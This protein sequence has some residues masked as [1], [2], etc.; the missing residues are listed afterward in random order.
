MLHPLR[1]DSFDINNVFPTALLLQV[2]AR[3]CTG[4]AYEPC[5]RTF[6][7]LFAA[8][9]VLR[10]RSEVV[11]SPQLCKST[12]EV[13]LSLQRPTSCWRAAASLRWW[14]CG[15][16][17]AHC[18]CTSHAGPDASLWLE[19]LAG[20]GAFAARQPRT[21]LHADPPGHV[22]RSCRY[23]HTLCCCALCPPLMHMLPP[24][25]SSSC[26]CA[27]WSSSISPSRSSQH[28]CM[29]CPHAEHADGRC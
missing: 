15:S 13:L 12:V 11:F 6:T 8:R 23:R 10:Y 19:H 27:S 17:V 29:C 28:S 3:D 5:T 7:M 2:S 20:L 4:H 14:R 16:C 1:P 9:F 21:E 18:C 25:R 24:V 26:C 22:P